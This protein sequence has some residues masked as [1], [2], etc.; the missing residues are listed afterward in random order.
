[1][2]EKNKKVQV[3]AGSAK[4]RKLK[5]PHKSRPITNRAKASLFSILGSDI[6]NKRILDLFA[7]SGAL[8]IEALSRGAKSCTFVD[9]NKFTISDIKANLE[10]TGFA[11]ISVTIRQGIFYFLDETPYESYDIIF[12]DPPFGF[13]DSPSKV[14]RI[15]T[16]TSQI[17]T[18]KGGLIFKHPKSFSFPEIKTLIEADSR[19]FGAS[20]VTIWVKKTK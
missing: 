1:M 13:F 4:G 19:N 15:M 14:K 8:G 3:I 12:V 7:G 11:D 16:I 18:E 10:K 5:V 6:K 17:L 20:T 9:K 2:R